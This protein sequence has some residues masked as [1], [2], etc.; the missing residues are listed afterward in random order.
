MR[1]TAA[2]SKLKNRAAKKQKEQKNLQ[3]ERH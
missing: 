2:L 1:E 3:V